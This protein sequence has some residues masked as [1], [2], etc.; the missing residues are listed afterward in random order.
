MAGHLTS[1]RESGDLCGSIVQ[2][3]GGVLRLED[4][5][6]ALWAGSYNSRGSPFVFWDLVIEWYVNYV[7]RHHNPA[8]VN[9]AIAET[10]LNKV[11]IILQS[12]SFGIHWAYM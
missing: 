10:A 3:I 6:I 11:T 12:R 8:A 1:G 2:R 5:N 9:A 7:D 4:I